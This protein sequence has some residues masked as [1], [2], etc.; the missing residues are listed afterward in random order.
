MTKSRKNRTVSVNKNAIIRNRVDRTGKLRTETAGRDEDSIVAAISTSTRT[1]T[2]NLFI[3]DP[4]SGE[5]VRL[6][7]RLARTLFRLLA[8]HYGYT[9]KSLF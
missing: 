1:N 2:T 9:N 6:D 5:T 7:G 3:D 4:M 8:S